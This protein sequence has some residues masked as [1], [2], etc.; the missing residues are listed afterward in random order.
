MTPGSRHPVATNTDLNPV[1]MH[2]TIIAPAHIVFAAPDQF[3][4]R[5]ANTFCNRGRFTWHMRISRRTPP[6]TAT[7]KLG[8]ESNVFGL[9]TEHLSDRNLV[10]RLKL[11]RNPR[12]RLVTFVFD[13]RVERLHRRVGEERKLILS[14][15]VVR[16]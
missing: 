13:C 4:W 15:E 5:T 14:N 1:H 2:R 12:F 10:H 16:A 3:D 11:R 9:E 7:G 6:K 8:M